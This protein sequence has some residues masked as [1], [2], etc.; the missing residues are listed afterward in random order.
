[1]ESFNQ[2][3][4]LF[5]W[6]CHE[7]LMN[8]LLC[9]MKHWASHTRHD[10]LVSSLSFQTINQSFNEWM[11]THSNY[12]ILNDSLVYFHFLMKPSRLISF[13]LFEPLKINNFLRKPIKHEE[14][15]KLSIIGVL[16]LN[17]K[18][19]NSNFNF[20]W[21]K[22]TVQM[23]T[24]FDK[25]IHFP[26]NTIFRIFVMGYFH[27]LSLALKRMFENASLTIYLYL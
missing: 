8:E 26:S 9:Q 18:W 2:P 7:K 4:S 24:I 6:T 23:L 15:W 25:T 3:I 12:S 5:Q 19:V 27:L 1:M 10:C 13:C 20:N 14:K 17:R 21:S 22:H 16:F 11:T